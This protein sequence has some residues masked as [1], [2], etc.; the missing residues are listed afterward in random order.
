MDFE[1]QLNVRV[2]LKYKNLYQQYNT[3][4]VNVLKEHVDIFLQDIDKSEKNDQP[5]FGMYI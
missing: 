5:P 4:P 1:N 3:L 2:K